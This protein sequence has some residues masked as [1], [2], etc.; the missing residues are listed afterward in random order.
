MSDPSPAGN[1]QALLLE[2]ARRAVQRNWALAKLTGKVPVQKAWQ[3]RKPAELSEVEKWVRGGA[4]LG[5]RTGKVSGVIAIDDDSVDGSAA[6]TLNLPPTVTVITGTG[7]RHY[8]FKAPVDFA[9]GNSV[10]TLADGIDVRGDGGQV[11]FVG[12]THPDTGRPYVWAP[13]LSPDEVAIAD[14]PAGILDRLRPKVPGK[15]AKL[16]L[17]KEGKEKSTPT[18]RNPELLAAYARAAR[19]SELSRVY[20]AGEGGL[21][22]AA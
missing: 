3:K 10:K 22:T 9:V 11:V 13:G 8:Y 19:D 6:L 15:A 7:K 18:A 4:N 17:V 21:S 14:L 16:K 1:P 2:E 5:L 12:S 20:G